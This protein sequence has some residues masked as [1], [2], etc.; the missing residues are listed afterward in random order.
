MQRRLMTLGLTLPGGL[1][2]A[3]FMIGPC[4]LVLAYAF[5]T[6]GVYGGVVHDLT[7]ENIFRVFDGLYV[8]IFL[9]SVRI[10]LTSAFVSL[11]I[12]YPA[13]YAISRAPTRV[14]FSL[15][16]LVI[17][18]FWSNYLIRTYA[19][20]VLL[21]RTGVMNEALMATGLI[22]SPVEMLYTE[23]AVVL[24]LVYNYLPFVVLAVYSSIQR[25]NPEV[26]EASEDLGAPGWTTFWRVTLPLTLPGVVAGG[27]FVFV[28]SIGNFVTP[29][30]L[31]GGQ[32]TMLGNLIYDQFM[33]ARDWP[34]GSAISLV[35][36]TIMM[37][38]LGIQAQLG[39]R[40]RRFD[41][42]Q[43]DHA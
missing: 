22:S 13:A 42:G 15:L 6:R 34:F 23:S 8:R 17:L 1:W 26:L 40:S 43:D 5:M 24:G 18:P 3:L 9:T 16:L 2:L 7:F 27:V 10:A 28:L 38:L 19:W 14:Q 37:V 35:L 25:L 36:I 21:S 29:D 4:G 32:I 20:I 11:L 33:S 12:G 31:G 39:Q 30:L 41:A